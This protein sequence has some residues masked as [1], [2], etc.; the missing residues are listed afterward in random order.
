MYVLCFIEKILEEMV[1]N[2]KNSMEEIDFSEVTP[3][4]VANKRG[5][6]LNLVQ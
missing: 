6:I 5:E 4:Y 3:E 2:N 1:K